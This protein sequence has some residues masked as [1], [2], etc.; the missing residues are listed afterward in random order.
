VAILAS[1]QWWVRTDGDNTNGGGYDSAISGAGTNYCD[2]AAAQ[3]TLTDLATSGAG[4]TTLTSATGGFT[5]AMIGNCI[6]I[7]AGTNFQT[8]YYFITARTDTNT[9]TL[10]RTPTSGGA[11]SGGSG[12]LGGA[13]ASISNLRAGGFWGSA[14]G[15]TSPLA[16]GHTVNVR[17]SGSDNPST[18]DWD[19]TGSLDFASGDYTT[20]GLIAWKGYNG[21]PFLRSNG[22]FFFSGVRHYFENMKFSTTGV[23]LDTHILE[24][25]SQWL[26]NVYFDMNG[27]DIGAVKHGRTIENCWFYNSGST[28]AGTA[29]ILRT[30]S[31]ELTIIGCV[32]ENIRGFVLSGS[33]A[34]SFSNNI[35]RNIKNTTTV[36]SFSDSNGWH[37]QQVVMNNV[38]YGNTATAVYATTTVAGLV[39]RNNIFVNNGAYGVHF[40]SNSSS[41]AINTRLARQSVDFNA[42]YNN[43]SGQCNGV[44]GGAN[45]I[46]LTG[47]PFINAAA[48]D[49]RLNNVAGAGAALRAAGFPGTFPGGYGNV[50]YSDIGAVQHQSSVTPAEVA[51]AM[52]EYANRE[53]T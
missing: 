53:L 28:S 14:P 11:G 10:D 22:T 18:P 40:T 12:K 13:F 23:A 49:F 21:R 3:L 25:D 37:P 47:D 6:R 38:F 35:V 44:T 34:C 1:A 17:G 5:T 51:E 20:G 26:R 31:R 16:A 7:S 30:S 42:Y 8:G 43:T 48:G 45:E 52:W 29:D 36:L 33:Y 24:G 50:S 39:V 27:Q 41:A 9:V 15:I 19:G 32:F 4:S 2:Q 46:T